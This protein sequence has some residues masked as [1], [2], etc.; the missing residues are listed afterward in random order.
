[1]GFRVLPI[2][3]EVPEVEVNVIPFAKLLCPRLLHFV[4]LLEWGK[5]RKSFPKYLGQVYDEKVYS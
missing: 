1:M 3:L 5:S 2:K 4:V